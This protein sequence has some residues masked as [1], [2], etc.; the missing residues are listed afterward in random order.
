[1]SL[2]YRNRNDYYKRYVL[3]EEQEANEAMKVG[4][5][6]HQTLEDERYPWQP[7]LLKLGWERKQLRP[8]RK[9]LDKA[10]AKRFGQPEV[11][12]I[13]ETKSGIKLFGIFDCYDKKERII[14]DWKVTTQKDDKWLWYQK[15]VD[16]AEQF[17]FYAYMLWLTNYAY[18]KEIII[19]PLN[20]TKGTCKT[21]KTVRDRRSIDEIAEKIE[22]FV[23]ELK[24]L[25]W[26]SKRPG[27]QEKF[28]L[29]T[30]QML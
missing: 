27:R 7:E 4:T 18:F 3:G 2:F 29:V 9:M 25:G 15:R 11:S 16:Y 23:D 19:H 13:A 17:T 1:M 14:A 6:I 22:R 21:F 8:V 5:I 26:W 20:A 24:R 12:M 30:D 10:L 28:K